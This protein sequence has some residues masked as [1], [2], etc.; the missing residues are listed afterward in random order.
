MFYK[1]IE[2]G[3]YGAL[4]ILNIG[5]CNGCKTHIKSMFSI[6]F[7]VPSPCYQVTHGWQV[8]TR[9]MVSYICCASLS[10]SSWECACKALNGVHG[11]PVHIK[12]ACNKSAIDI[13]M[14][15]GSLIRVMSLCPG[16]QPCASVRWCLCRTYL[17][18]SWAL[19]A[20]NCSNFFV[21]ALYFPISPSNWQA[22]GKFFSRKRW[23]VSSRSLWDLVTSCVLK[24]LLEAAWTESM[25][26]QPSK[27]S[28]RQVANIRW[29]E[30]ASGRCFAKPAMVFPSHCLRQGLELI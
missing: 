6:F 15:W 12:A 7:Y 4:R 14:P 26:Y 16:T 1:T 8:F 21:V 24:Y 18:C 3:V 30:G 29:N 25:G 19:H 11:N 28:N 5:Y 17:S 23:A 22:F 27:A 13:E 2:L 10:R 9:R 20:R